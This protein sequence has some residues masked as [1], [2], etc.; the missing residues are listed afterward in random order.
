MLAQSSIGVSTIGFSRVSNLVG[1][2][3]S[4]F[5][6]PGEGLLGRMGHRFAVNVGNHTLDLYSEKGLDYEFGV[7]NLEHCLFM[8]LRGASRIHYEAK[9]SL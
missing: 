3:L 1:L 9:S 5:G 4:R 2:E 7:A 8:L 6:P